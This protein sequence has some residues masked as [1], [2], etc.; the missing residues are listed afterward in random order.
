MKIRAM[1]TK[2]TYMYSNKYFS[3][4]RI[5]PLWWYY[6]ASFIFFFGL[7]FRSHRSCWS[8]AILFKQELSTL[9]LITLPLLSLLHSAFGELWLRHNP[10]VVCVCVLISFSWPVHIIFPQHSPSFLLLC[11]CSS[12]LALWGRW[13]GSLASCLRVAKELF[14]LSPGVCVFVFLTSLLSLFI[15]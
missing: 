11:S 8:L 3:K 14:V 4:I 5:Q 10:Y 6:P 13:P 2:N 7:A 15:H 9:F 12:V 1:L